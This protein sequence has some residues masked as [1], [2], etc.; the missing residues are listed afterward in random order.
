MFRK[1][2]LAISQPDVR[3]FLYETLRDPGEAKREVPD[4]VTARDVDDAQQKI[5][6]QENYGFDLIIIDA[7]IRPARKSGSAGK[8]LLG[9]KLLQKWRAAGTDVPCIVLVDDLDQ[10]NAVQ[11]VQDCEPLTVNDDTG[12][13]LVGVIER[14]GVTAGGGSHTK[15]DP[16]RMR[17]G[18]E[19]TEALPPNGDT[20]NI[21]INLLSSTRKTFRLTSV[22]SKGNELNSEGTLDLDWEKLEDLGERTVELNGKDDWEVNL[23]RIGDDLWDL[24]LQGRF[25]DKFHQV[26]G[27][28]PLANLHIRFNVSEE[29][30]D[31]AFEALRFQDHYMM[32]EA[33]LARKVETDSRVR[34][35]QLGGSK[36]VNVLFV[37]ADV[38]AGEYVPEVLDIN[39]QDVKFETLENLEDEREFFVEVRDNRLKE[40]SLGLGSIDFLSKSDLE[41]QDCRSFRQMLEDK[42]TNHQYDIVHFAGHSILDNVNGK[43]KK[44]KEKESYLILPGKSP[45]ALKIGTFARWLEKSETKF[46]FLSSCESSA[47]AAVFELAYRGVSA[48]VGFRWDLIDP[49]AADF[50]KTFYEKLF[51]GPSPT[52]DVAFLQTRVH[53]EDEY[54]KE[55]IWAA[56]ILIL[57]PRE[58]YQCI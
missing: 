45:E 44:G 33:P 41:H 43:K 55:Q 32:L 42:L 25:R 29:V 26:K 58:W 3:D 52:I 46:V 30:Y 20:A 47:T 19:E 5:D 9:L 50:V 27:I 21:E 57:Q 49:H 22:L 18:S 16:A 48:V 10:I 38:G 54:E 36:P 11:Q 12:K 56:P 37:E 14:M 17:S 6:D 53:M 40:S 24:L 4:V 1:I 2:L 28:T 7:N 34:P 51:F 35:L 39:G 8:S 15:C 13:A 31:V 23:R